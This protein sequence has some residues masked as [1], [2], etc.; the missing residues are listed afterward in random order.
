MLPKICF[1]KE[2]TA[3]QH[4][5]SLDNRIKG[6]YE[7]FFVLLLLSIF[8]FQQSTCTSCIIFSK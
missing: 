2:Y 5:L 3:N 7:F 1:L 6:A 8:Y 4:R